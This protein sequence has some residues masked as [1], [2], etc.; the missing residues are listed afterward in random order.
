MKIS[1]ETWK[2]VDP[3]FSAALGMA[4]DERGAW[5]GS[6]RER[7]PGL[8]PIVEELLATHD[9]LERATGI[10]TVPRLA[11]PP[12]GDA[13]AAGETIGPF[14]LVR[15][16]GRGGM[17]EVWLAEQADGR[18]ERKVALKLPTIF[19]AGG[20][21]A[22][23]FRRERDILAKLEHPNIARLYDA[24]VTERGQPWLAMEFVQGEPLD[25]HA[26][27]CRLA[28]RDR[29]LLMRQVLAAVAHAHRFLVVH[30]DLKPANILVDASGQ[31]KLLDFGI[32]KLLAD[33]TQ[34]G[35][36]PADLTRLGGRL[37][38]PRYA[39]PEQA[40]EGAITT[41]T[42]V[43]SL[44]VI[45]HEALTGLSPYRLVR[46]GRSF[47]AA[48]LAGVEIARPSTIAPAP[49]ARELAGDLDAIL[50]KA[51]RRDPAAR[52]ATVGEFDE[53]I[54]RHL[55]HLPVRA[56]EG[57]WRYLAG[58]YVRRHRFAIAMSAAVVA[59]L[60][61]GLVVAESQRARAE[62]HFAEVRKLAN[63]FI[64]DVHGAIEKLPGSLAA[65]QMLVKT[66]L[67]YLDSLARETGGDP[68]LRREIASGYRKI[69]E[70]EGDTQ[71]ANVGEAGAA[72]R[73][74]QKS[75]ALLEALD[76]DDPRNLETLR[77]LRSA[78]S[79]LARLLKDAGDPAAIPTREAVVAV[80]GRAATLPAA[81]SDDRREHA[82]AVA[83]LAVDLSVLKSDRRAARERVEKAM[84]MLDSLGREAPGDRAV[85]EAQASTYE[86]AS[87]I[88]EQSLRP[89]D[90][91][92]AVDLMQRSAGITERLLK[93]DPLDQRFEQGLVK[94]LTN[95]AQTQRLAGDLPG[96]ARNLARA[97]EVGAAS[98]AREPNNA[99]NAVAYLRAL[100]VGVSVEQ[101]LGRHD[102]AI[103]VGREVESL[104]AKLPEGTRSGIR[105]R[106]NVA[107]ARAFSGL[108]YLELAESSKAAPAQRLAMARRA[109]SLLAESRAFR[110]EMA[111]R[112][113]DAATSRKLVE[114]IGET[115]AR[116]DALI[117]RLGG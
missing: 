17:G 40:T 71:N 102:A 50:L 116:C 108:A 100:A 53:D 92:Q 55:G 62:R 46:E 54:G 2:Q 75:V 83:D 68:G 63:T 111:D 59:A 85:R 96:A 35:A 27:A 25:A 15:P 37:M 80:A 98:W 66:S 77:E 70:I 5:L 69:A 52:Y 104:E 58:R 113:L 48:A 38:T 49:L 64:F 41:A 8:A 82:T 61:A 42:D 72:R 105:V 11:A 78:K 29:L 30:R 109:R 73:H 117:A 97:R 39:A 32:A 86:R 112:D 60:S 56:R 89:E 31:V 26:A 7:Q 114:Q 12:P 67:D 84:E 74:A 36:P 4:P 103:T 20:A 22:E 9:R 99:A 65:R 88:V 43:Y 28:I 110:Q 57:T 6:L 44:G 95:L 24:G 94:R 13:F 106:A 47:T 19:E 21:R 16:L 93:E 90:L 101:S 45:L 10:E 79:L 76:R 87:I 91:P 23:R 1:P 3:L 107:T 51:L 33:E 14:R 18:V 81:T 34:P 115:I